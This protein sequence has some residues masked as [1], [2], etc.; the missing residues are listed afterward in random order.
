MKK[1]Y[2]HM[3]QFQIGDG[4]PGTWSV[5]HRLA[6]FESIFARITD[7]KWKKPVIATYNDSAVTKTAKHLGLQ[8]ET[9]REWLFDPAYTKLQDNI[10]ETFTLD[11]SE[12]ELH[13]DICK[14]LKLATY[15]CDIRLHLQRP[16]EMIALHVDNRK[17]H[18]FDLPSDKEHL[19]TRYAIF[20][21]DQMP[22][23]AWMIN[24]DY[25]KWKRGDVYT[26]GQS[27]TPHGTANFS[28]HDRPVL[29]VTGMNIAD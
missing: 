14:L 2:E 26:W 8:E 13:A 21:E 24:H 6:D 29:V 17:H 9:I 16:G 25:I 27:T 18:V 3:H 4:G 15:K 11:D 12:V 10:F 1:L 20:L 5:A 28:Y 22:G 7:A 19:V 23:Q